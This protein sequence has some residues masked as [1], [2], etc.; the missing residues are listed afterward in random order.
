MIYPRR[1]IALF[2]VLALA[3]VGLYL[4]DFL[5]YADR[6]LWHDEYITWWIVKDGLWKALMRYAL[7]IDRVPLYY[8]LL[9]LYACPHWSCFEL[10]SRTASVLAVIFGAMILSR[11]EHKSN[12]DTFPLS[13]LILLVSSGARFSAF[14]ARPYAMAILFSSLI[15]SYLASFKEMSIFRYFVISFLFC[16]LALTHLS[17]LILIAT[18]ACIIIFRW[19]PRSFA[20][21]VAFVSLIVPAAFIAIPVLRKILSYSAIVDFLQSAP[22]AEFVFFTCTYPFFVALII[23]CIAS[24]KAKESIHSSFGQ[25]KALLSEPIVQ[26]FITGA[27]GYFIALHFIPLSG[28]CVRYLIALLPFMA[29]TT[30]RIA[31]KARPEASLLALA[32]PFLWTLY[33]G[34]GQDATTDWSPVAK[35]I[36]IQSKCPRVFS[37]TMDISAQRVEAYT[38]PEFFPYLLAPLEY[39]RGEDPRIFPI[40]GT[41]DVPQEL[42]SYWYNELFPAMKNYSCIEILFPCC[43]SLESIQKKEAWFNGGLHPRAYSALRKY[44]IESG[45]KE[46]E[47]PIIGGTPLRMVRYVSN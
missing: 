20:K 9:S 47:L 35:L 38:N 15:V 28:R 23:F 14:S 6:P 40:P 5:N 32:L 19:P 12:P 11:A 8:S 4:V 17:S 29:W 36:E 2:A 21:I 3:V 18:A 30:S 10:S 27:I 43:E 31:S 7:F 16:C 42:H 26:I 24:E 33:T 22:S 25:L 39:Y 41:F 45:W 34:D 1:L 13:G 46:E 37:P 44:L